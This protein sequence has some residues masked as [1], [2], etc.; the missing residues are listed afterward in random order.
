G[1]ER[2]WSG[3]VGEAHPEGNVPATPR[4]LYSICSISKLFTSMAVMQLR[5]RGQL[6]LSDP[7]AD[8]LPWYRMG[9]VEG[10]SP[11]VTIEGILTHSA[12]LPRESDHAYW[13]APDFEFPTREEIIE[14]LRNQRALYPAWR[15]FQYS[16]LGLTLAGEI[17]RERSGMPYADYVRANILEPL[18][19]AD[20]R[21]EMPE[22]ERGGRLAT[23]HSAIGRDGTRKPVPFFQARGIAP[24]AG[25]SST[26]EDLA[27]FA[28]W[29]FGL[30]EGDAVLHPHTLQEMQR[31]HYVD[32]GWNTF[33]GLGFGVQRHDD[34]TLV[35][36][37]GSCPG[38]RSQLLLDMEDEIAT[39]IMANASGVNAGK[40]VRGMY[41]LV[42]PALRALE[43]DDEA[44][45]EA[46]EPG[47]TEPGP[48]LDDYV[49]TYSVQP[50]GGETAVVRWKGGLALLP[51]P[52]DD[53]A[54]ALTR[55][56]HVEADAFRRIRD[57]DELG[58]S[59]V[60]ERDGSGRVVRLR[61][62][63]NLYPRVR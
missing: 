3:A 29:Q 1:Q 62:F 35:G 49:G 63:N 8:H 22:A 12:G 51:L 13:S 28:A 44:A 36:H 38:Y 54:E 57:D 55:L 17:V 59:V 48:R 39:V 58:E 7:I 24:A 43:D 53:P 25:Y 61:R 26:V 47:G 50:W 10:S 60:F 40:F 41:D 16:N 46:G 9:E 2:I 37:G 4:T 27:R 42:A 33:W 31:V 21:P 5:D 18:G 11:P 14:G 34:R 56:E 30:E 52:T 19:L 6:R 20:T 23:G 32:P 45:A 15:Y